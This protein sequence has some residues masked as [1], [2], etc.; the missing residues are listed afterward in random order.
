M[1]LENG[2]Q[3]SNQ[4]IYIAENANGFYL[5]EKALEYL[6]IISPTFPNVLES[7]GLTSDVPLGITFKT[8]STASAVHKPILIPYHWKEDV[9]KGI[10]Q[11]VAMGVIET[12][13][14]GTPSVWCSRMVVTPKKGGSPL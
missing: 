1:R 9:K 5:S 10:N 3:H 6:G 2:K 13:P 14:Q 7:N 12:V 8:N 4:I 11:D